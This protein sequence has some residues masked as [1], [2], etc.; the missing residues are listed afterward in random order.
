MQSGKRSRA[1]VILLGIGAV[2][3]LLRIMTKGP[4]WTLGAVVFLLIGAL[5]NKNGKKRNAKL[6]EPLVQEA[7][8]AVFPAANYVAESGIG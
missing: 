4:G 8:A 2:C 5:T 7:V 6:Q 3:L 1:G